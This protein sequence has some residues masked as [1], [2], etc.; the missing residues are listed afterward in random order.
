MKGRFQT[1]KVSNQRIQTDAIELVM[2]YI[3]DIQ[4]A[5]FPEPGPERHDNQAATGFDVVK[6][7]I[8]SGE[9]M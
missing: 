9:M 6:A 7:P 1:G 8:P 2:V 3:L 4:A 5:N